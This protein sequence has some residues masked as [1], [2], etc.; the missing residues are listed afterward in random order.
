MKATIVLIFAAS[1][2]LLAGCCTTHQATHW[3]YMT[4]HGE[5]SV[6]SLNKL[7]DQGWSVVGFTGDASGQLDYLLKRPKQ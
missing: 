6:T 4:L 1:T 7:S 3:E 5:Q 2:L